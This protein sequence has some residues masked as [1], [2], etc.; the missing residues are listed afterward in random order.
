MSESDNIIFDTAS[1]IFGDLSTPEVINAAEAGQWPQE[2]WQAIEESGLTL[3]WIPEVNGGVGASMLDGFAVIKAAGGAPLPVPLAETLMAGWLLARGGLQVAVEP[4]TIALLDRA[5][6]DLYWDGKKLGGT[7][8]SVP[9]G[10]NARHIVTVVD[11]NGQSLVLKFAVDQ[12]AIASHVN[13][14]GEP[15]DTVTFDNVV[16]T[17]ISELEG[18]VNTGTVEALGALV[19]CVQSAG[20]LSTALELT[21]QYSMERVQFGRPIAK[22]QALQ[23]SVATFAG[24]VAAINAAADSAAEAVSFGGLIDHGAWIEI[25]TAKT[26]LEE[27]VNIG[28]AVAHQ[29]HGAMGFTYEHRLHHLTRR[30]WSWRDEYGSD[31]VWADRLGEEVLQW[32][33]E[34]LWPHITAVSDPR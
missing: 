9:H 17:E 19:R 7:A 28:A 33:S 2:L 6:G 31:S 20:A 13:L 14:A 25:A 34:G 29:V 11:A 24:Q 27:A 21:L 22:F 15:W 32:G 5:R 26:R 3:T 12:L 23:H 16:P 10:R 30:L 1:R 4:M 18:S 8:V